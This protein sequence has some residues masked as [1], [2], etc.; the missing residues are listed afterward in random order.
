MVNIFLHQ[1]SSFF[2]F[3]AKV[4][5]SGSFAS[6]ETEWRRFTSV[7]NRN[8][9]WLTGNYPVS[10]FPHIGLKVFFFFFFFN[11]W[12]GLAY[13]YKYIYL[14][15][16]SLGSISFIVYYPRHLYKQ[17]HIFGSLCFFLSLLREMGVSCGLLWISTWSLCLYFLCAGFMDCST[18]SSFYTVL[19]IEPWESHGLHSW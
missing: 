6:M 17:T 3:G 1:L 16:W 14:G 8:I 19:G 15:K 4:L 12:K 5:L 9:Q 13:I 18:I 7:T 10:C 2:N 11:S